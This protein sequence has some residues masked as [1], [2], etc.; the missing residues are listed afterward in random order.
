MSTFS[1]CWV[2]TSA[3]KKT[4]RQ[5]GWIVLAF[6]AVATILLA[7]ALAPTASAVGTAPVYLW[8]WGALGAN[9]GE[10]NNPRSVALDAQGNV[11]V[12]DSSNQRIQ[13]F[14]NF[15]NFITLWGYAGNGN[16][17][18][19]EPRGIGIN[20]NGNLY[21]ADSGNNRI[22]VFDTEGNY[23][24]QWGSLGAGDNQ[25]NFPRGICFDAS[26]NVYIADWNNNRM[27]EFDANGTYIRKWGSLGSGNSQ[28]DAPH[29]CVIDSA[30]DIY[31]VEQDNHRVQ[32]FDLDATPPTY[33][34]K[35]GTE[36][37][38]NGQFNEPHGIL[39]D[40]ENHIHVADTLNHRIQEFTNT[41]TFVRAWGTNGNSDGQFNE[42]RDVKEDSN[43]NFFVADT[44]NHRIQKF[45]TKY[46]ASICDAAQLINA[47]YVSNNNAGADTL[48]LDGTCTYTLTQFVGYDEIN[49]AAF[50]LP[51]FT[52]DITIHGNGA[53]IERDTGAGNF[54][55]AHVSNT[56]TLTLQ[57]LT[58]QN[59]RA[60]YTGGA[61][62]NFGA[63]TIIAST[64]ANNYAPDS[65]GAIWNGGTVLIDRST[66]RNNNS[67]KGSAIFLWGGGPTDTPALRIVNSTLAENTNSAAIRSDHNQTTLIINSTIARNDSGV[68]NLAAR[69]EFTNSILANTY[70]SCNKW[71]DTE[72]E[73]VFVDNGN[74]IDNDTT[75]EFSAANN[76][77]PGT[78]ALLDASGLQ[79]NGGPTQ[80]IALQDGSPALD[81]GNDTVCAAAP[82][83]AVDQ[84]GVTRPQVNHCDIG[85]FEVEQA[86][87]DTDG[88]GVLNSND[89]CP[90]TPNPDQADIDGDTI[91]DVCDP[92]RD[93][94]GVSNENDNC[95]DIS[96]PDQADSDGDGIGDVCEL[97][98]ILVEEN[99]VSVAFN[100]WEGEDNANASGGAYRESSTKNDTVTFQFTGKKITWITRKGPDMGKAQV[101]IDGVD[102][103]IIDLYN[104]S[105]IWQFNKS[106]KKLSNTKHTI[107]IQVLDTKNKQ[108][109]DTKVSIDAFKVGTNV[110]EETALTV[111]YNKWN[112]KANA[113][114]SGGSFR[115]SKK[116]NAVIQFTFTGTEV[117][118][119]TAKGPNNGK[120]RV[121][122]DGTD[123]GVF[124]LYASP[125]QW[126]VAMLFT[127]LGAGQHTIEIQVLGKKNAA[128]KG[129]AV[130]VD[131]F[132]GP[133]Q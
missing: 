32:K 11:Y 31:V 105:E 46:D 78:D 51:L 4:T 60:Q 113:A 124:D 111:R 6:A 79:N 133:F 125:A 72:V 100:G 7:T 9:N 58:I 53:T 57:Q 38:G 27:M 103:G 5:R 126:Q 86:V 89:N 56:G 34:Q 67:Y 82:V 95:P 30:N 121:V 88:D 43:G 19:N 10:F 66:L 92:D 50:G 12:A 84:R 2:T 104:A 122:I 33:L 26:N 23:I 48:E 80:T 70:S 98:I 3:L 68:D 35:W 45:G 76:S 118:W 115:L 119:L 85:A 81:A 54:G 75:C 16:G 99:D 40:S 62:D 47:I 28:F 128:S 39:L 123:K 14:D 1:Q 36:G 114:A 109:S 69:V 116:Q 87:G 22:Q 74:N 59:G 25:F 49:S 117:E 77:H 44:K 13:K 130:V 107:V 41:G 91:G 120:A 83:N 102:K 64:L 90:I 96:N 20:G 71:T 94:D 108:A 42:P 112:G 8:K 52:T 127:G 61:V 21:V 73:P 110:T 129:N 15:G 93:G 18:F 63:L 17:Q 24:T 55:I 106:F 29:G 65:G 37:A 131:A 101:K 97:P 132:R